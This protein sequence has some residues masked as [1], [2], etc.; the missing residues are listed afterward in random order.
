MSVTLTEA[1][2][3]SALDTYFMSNWMTAYPAVLFDLENVQTTSPAPG[4]PWVRCRLQ[5]ENS[6]QETLGAPGARQ[7]RRDA[8]VWCWCFVAANSGTTLLNGMIDTL[9]TMFEGVTF[10]GIS[11]RGAVRTVTTGANGQWYEV[12]VIAP[13][14]YT[15]TR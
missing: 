6:V 5:L 14:M 11:P 13:V 3:K 10:S 12:A 1:Q 15:Q 9:R 4:K 7:Y 8:A 2:A